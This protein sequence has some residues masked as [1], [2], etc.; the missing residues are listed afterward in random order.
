MT[1][2]LTFSREERVLRITLD[3]AEKRNALTSAM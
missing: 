1:E 3:R 2:N